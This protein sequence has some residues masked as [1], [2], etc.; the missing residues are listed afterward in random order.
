LD[1]I[2]VLRNKINEVQK[3]QK[4]SRLIPAAPQKNGKKVLNFS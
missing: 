1:F 2:K 4:K 3:W